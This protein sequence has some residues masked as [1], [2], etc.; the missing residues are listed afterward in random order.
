MKMNQRLKI[1]Y[2]FLSGAY[3]YTIPQATT[4]NVASTTLIIDAITGRTLDRKRL[5]MTKAKARNITYKFE[6]LASKTRS[7]GRFDVKICTGIMR[8]QASTAIA[9]TGIRACTAQRQATM[10]MSRTVIMK[11]HFL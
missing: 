4:Y 10:Y 2:G 7:V 11:T 9:T 3:V 8:T 5:Y 1:K 6:V